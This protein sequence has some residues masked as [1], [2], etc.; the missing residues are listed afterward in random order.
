MLCNYYSKTLLTAATNLADSRTSNPVC[1]LAIS[2]LLYR[3]TK[4]FVTGVRAS[5]CA[6]FKS[7]IVQST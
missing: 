1:E 4:I 3:L 5:L 2:L 7:C 6:I